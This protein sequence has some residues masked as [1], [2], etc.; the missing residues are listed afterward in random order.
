M[1]C[2]TNIGYL[3]GVL[4]NDFYYAMKFYDDFV[5][6]P[7]TGSNYASD[8]DGTITYANM[9]TNINNG[10]PFALL[11]LA[12]STYGFHYIDVF[13]YESN[14]DGDY[15]RVADGWS[16]NISTF[17]RYDSVINNISV[18]HMLDGINY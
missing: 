13:G 14:S 9:K 8:S 16:N 5:R 4:P 10:A 7:V 6:V 17:V 3:Q 12:D 1:S 15:L 2:N 11:L 18:M